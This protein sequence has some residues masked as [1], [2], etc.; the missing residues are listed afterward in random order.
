M[1]G[2]RLDLDF[3]PSQERSFEFGYTRNARWQSLVPSEDR[4]HSREYITKVGAE[5][6]WKQAASTSQSA[7]VPFDEPTLGI[8]GMWRLGGGANPH[9]ALALGEIMMRVGQRQIAWCAY[10]RAAQLAE[11]VWPDPVIQSKFAEHCRKRQSVIERQLTDEEREELSPRLKAELAYGRRYQEEYQV[12]EAKRIREGASLD[13][14]HFYDAFLA[15]HEPIASPVGDE[16]YIQVTPGTWPSPNIVA[17]VLLAGIF[18][19]VAACLY[20][21][22]KRRAA[23]Q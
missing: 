23:A 16:E 10:E 18:A 22:I 17:I 19:F 9:F 13:D 5:T 2:N 7:P 1:V 12:Y 8:I 15:E 6:E 21:L 4:E 3:D 20:R 11:R 14:E